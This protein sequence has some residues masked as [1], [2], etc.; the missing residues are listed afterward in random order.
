MPKG[1][2]G[3]VKLAK[4][5]SKSDKEVS[6]GIM[7]PMLCDIAPSDCRPPLYTAFIL[8]SLLVLDYLPS[9]CRP[10]PPLQSPFLSSLS[11]AGDSSTEQGSFRC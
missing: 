1:P 7:P 9:A 2:S 3:K 11:L 8:P 10:R 4:K 5:A 6:G